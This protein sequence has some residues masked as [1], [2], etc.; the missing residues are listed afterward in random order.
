MSELDVVEHNI[1]SARLTD[2]PALAQL[3]YTFRGGIELAPESEAAFVTR[4][5]AWMTPRLAPGSG[6]QC[7]V[8]EQEG[9]LVGTVWLQLFE[10]MPNPVALEAEWHGYVSNLY[11]APSLRGGGL[12][13]RLLE[14]CLE[15]CDTGEVDAVILWPTPRSRSLYE[16]HGFAVRNDLLERR[17][18]DPHDPG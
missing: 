15:A 13:S 16:R 6:W 2:I 1:R 4:C 10:K 11:V 7:W 9:Q 8:A 5:A 12:G 3:R 17:S 18:R 14:I